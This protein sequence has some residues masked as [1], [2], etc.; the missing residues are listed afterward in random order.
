MTL[1]VV[2]SWKKDFRPRWKRILKRSKQDQH[3]VEYRFRLGFLPYPHDGL[4]LNRFV[5]YRYQPFLC[6]Y[7]IQSIYILFTASMARTERSHSSADMV[8]CQHSG[9]PFIFSAA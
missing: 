9:L 8:T 4:L 7:K 2:K 5:S 3:P 1:P 6:I